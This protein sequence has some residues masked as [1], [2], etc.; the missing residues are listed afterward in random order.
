MTVS[1]ISHKSSRRTVP[2]EYLLI[3]ETSES[4]IIGIE[5]LYRI[6]KN[7]KSTLFKTENDYR[8]IINTRGFT[9]YL[10]TLRE[11]CSYFSGNI[12]NTEFTKEH[13]EILIKEN[14]VKEFGKHFFKDF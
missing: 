4:L 11:Y 13:G 9:P 6:R 3:F 12:Y 1:K 14:A 8:L 10:I 2:R 5:F 7:I